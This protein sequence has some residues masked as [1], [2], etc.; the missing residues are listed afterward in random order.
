MNSGAMTAADNFEFDYMFS[1]DEDCII[2]NHKIFEDLI[3]LDKDFV[4]PLLVDEKGSDYS[5]IWPG[6]KEEMARM[7]DHTYLLDYLNVADR[8]FSGFWLVPFVDKC[9]LTKRHLIDKIKD[10]YKKNFDSPVIQQLDP[11][12]PK[13]SLTFC[14]NMIEQGLF[15]YV[16]NRKSH[17]TLAV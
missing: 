8:N 13:Q 11:T 10:F 5:N 2:R 9:F 12:Y 1:M 17:G 6:P 14:A 16:D 3:S 4:A 7:G 15:M